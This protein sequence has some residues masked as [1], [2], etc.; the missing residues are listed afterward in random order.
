[1]IKIKLL[2]PRYANLKDFILALPDRMDFEGEYVYGGKRNLIKRFTAPDGE[3]LIVKRFHRPRF[4][5][6]LVYSWGI[7]KPK[8]VRAFTY[9]S[10]LREHGVETPEPIAYI[11]DRECGML[12]ESWLITPEIPYRHLLYEMGDAEPETYEPMAKALA[13]FTAQMHE[14]GVMHK[15]YSPGNILWDTDANGK[16]CF[17][18]VDINRMYFGPVDMKRG[19]ANFARLW[20]PKRF[21][22]LLATEYARLRGFNEQEAIGI[23]MDCRRKFW[24]RYRKRHEIKFKL[25]L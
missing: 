22:E 13:A 9:A 19:C 3:S 2:N 23:V 20:G 7:R 11:E 4:V 17:S 16:T 6:K 15:D 25:E 10:I 21:I 5:N 24:T 1:M 14:K 18:I 8:G 12:R